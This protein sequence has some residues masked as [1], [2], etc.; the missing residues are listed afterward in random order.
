VKLVRARYPF[1]RELEL[2]RDA[3]V[4]QFH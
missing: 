4:P 3:H 1:L 2:G